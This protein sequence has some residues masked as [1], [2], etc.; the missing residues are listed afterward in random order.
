MTAHVIRGE[1]AASLSLDELANELRLIQSGSK[2]IAIIGTRN[3]SI[4]HQQIIEFISN[5]L[6]VAGNTIVTSGG[7]SGVNFAA[8]KGAVKGDTN[9]LEVI[10]PQTAQQQSLEL[11]EYLKTLKIVV[12]HP[13]RLEMEFSEASRICYHEI[14]DSCHQLI[15]FVYHDSNT[16]LKA[17]EYAKINHKIVTAFYLD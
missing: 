17:I 12:E 15:C 11:Q 6:V 14:I 10:L 1:N 13:E 5:G 16:L 2:R 8:I 7:S 9:N 3:L 4:T